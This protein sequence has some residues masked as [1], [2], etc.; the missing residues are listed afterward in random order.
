MTRHRHQ[1]EM[2]RLHDAARELASNAADIRDTFNHDS[3]V[4]EF[5]DQT[6]A[7]CRDVSELLYRLL[8][9]KLYVREGK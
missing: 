8:G 9:G 3:E 6:A 1:E 7:L 5:A 4:A 2:A